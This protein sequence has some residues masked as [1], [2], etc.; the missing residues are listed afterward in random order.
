MTTPSTLDLEI[1]RGDD[2]YYQFQFTDD[3]DPP[4]ALDLSTYTF[5]AQIRDQPELGSKVYADFY[6]DDDDAADGVIVIHLVASD[7]TIPPGYWDLQ[8]DDGATI[9]T[10]IKGAVITSGDVTRET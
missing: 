9:Q 7:T 6:I 4:E 3:Q 5:T 1:Y 10:W 2:F 8:V